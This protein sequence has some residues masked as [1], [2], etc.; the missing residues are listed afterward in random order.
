MFHIVIQGYQNCTWNIKKYGLCKCRAYNIKINRTEDRVDPPWSKVR[1]IWDWRQRWSGPPK[2]TTQI[3]RWRWSWPPAK[4]WPQF[5]C[6]MVIITLDGSTCK[7]CIISTSAIYI[8]HTCE[9][10]KKKNRVHSR[11]WNWPVI[12][13]RNAYQFHLWRNL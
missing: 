13:S 9:K 6:H 1:D 5:G 4:N 7:T 12:M 8:W 2:G 3:W 10:V 11:K